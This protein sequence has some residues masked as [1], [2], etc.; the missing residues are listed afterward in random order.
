MEGFDL[1]NTRFFKN[2]FFMLCHLFTAST[3]DQPSAV[4]L[5]LA[6]FSAEN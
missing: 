5:G 1:E 6:K 4:V 2:S 3:A